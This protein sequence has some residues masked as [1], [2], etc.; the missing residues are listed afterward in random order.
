MAEEVDLNAVS[1]AYRSQMETLPAV[2]EVDLA[3]RGGELVCIHGGDLT[4]LVN[5]RTAFGDDFGGRVPSATA[6]AT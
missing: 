4:G 1:Y 2:D 6:A 3:V 5:G